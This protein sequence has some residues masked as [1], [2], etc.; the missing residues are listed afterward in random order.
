LTDRKPTRSTQRKSRPRTKSRVDDAREASAP[1]SS[2]R[3]RDPEKTRAR[4]LSAATNE[5]ALK[6]FDGARVDMIAKR[7]KT[8]K[9]M[10]Y[11]YFGDKK[12][13]F[14]AIVGKMLSEH[15]QTFAAAPTDFEDMVVYQFNACQSKSKWLRM[16]L[17]ESLAYG[18]GPVMA[19]RVRR[20]RMEKSR[21]RM[22]QAQR[23]GVMCSKMPSD[24]ALLAMMAM[25][26]FPWAFPQITRMLTGTA[27]SEKA[28]R[29]R[30]TEVLREVTR[31]M[32]P[33]GSAHATRAA[34]ELPLS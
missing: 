6:G 11:H 15:E 26:V 33:A 27:P 10:L 7:A 30:Y 9:R 2:G 22:R 1:R 21:E 31:R 28:F 19:E 8:N 3:A 24:H 13:L 14:E 25:S 20:E 12:A 5:F 4:I 32:K 18:E 29:D 17:W 23:D 16:M 34:R